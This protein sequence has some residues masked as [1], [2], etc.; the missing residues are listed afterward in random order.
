RSDDFTVVAPQPNQATTK[1]WQNGH[2]DITPNNPSGHLINPTQSMD[3]TCTERE[4][5][6]AEHS[7]TIN[8]VRGQNNE[9]TISNKPDYVTLDTQN[10]RER[11]N[12]SSVRPD[13]SITLTTEGGTGHSVS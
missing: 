12:D 2:I 5:K 7:N 6:F 9:W 3:I 4:V 8:F 11:L 1:I 13:T 10:G